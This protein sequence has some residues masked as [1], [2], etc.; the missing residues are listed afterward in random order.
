MLHGNLIQTFR[1][2][3]QGVEEPFIAH[4]VKISVRKKFIKRSQGHNTRLCFHH[5]PLS[6]LNVAYS[7]SH[8]DIFSF[9]DNSSFA[10]SRFIRET[11]NL[12]QFFHSPMFQKREHIFC[13]L[14]SHFDECVC[15]KQRRHIREPVVFVTRGQ[16][17]VKREREEE[18]PPPLPSG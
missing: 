17:F 10:A 3:A 8:S 11:M 7:H 4:F 12:N 16:A 13:F 14:C 15:I 18:K 6:A 9:R 1:L 5:L 2:R